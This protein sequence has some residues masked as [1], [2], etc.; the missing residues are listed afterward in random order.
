MPRSRAL[1][2]CGGTHV[3][4]GRRVA[5]QVMDAEKEGVCRAPLPAERD[6]LKNRIGHVAEPNDRQIIWRRGAPCRGTVAEVWFLS[7]L[8]GHPIRGSD[9]L[10]LHLDPTEDGP[11]HGPKSVFPAALQGRIDLWLRPAGKAST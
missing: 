1:Q 7:E 11:R 4:V 9:R 6:R 5:V 3:L 8:P 2:R 10:R